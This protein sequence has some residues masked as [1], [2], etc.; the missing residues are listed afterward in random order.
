LAFR[1]HRV[2]SRKLEKGPSSLLIDGLSDS[3]AL[4]LV[5]VE[6][7]FVDTAGGI[8][9]RIAVT[10]VNGLLQNT[11][12]PAVDEICVISISRR[13]AVREDE[14]LSRIPGLGPNTVEVGR[15]PVKFHENPRNDHWE[16]RVAARASI[17][18]TRQECDMGLMVRGVEVLSIPAAREINLRTNS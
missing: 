1:L 13:I 4:S 15:A 3:A 18:P 5:H 16:V 7:T 2:V 11:G 8:T 10:P 14:R 9:V 6:K 12:I 17:G